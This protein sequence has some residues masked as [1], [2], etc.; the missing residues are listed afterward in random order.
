MSQ[1][2]EITRQ[3]A[4]QIIRVNRPEKKNA[5]TRAMYGAM[6]KGLEAGEADD[7]IRCHMFLGVPGA[8]SAGNDMQDFLAY[9]TSG[10]DMPEL[11]GFLETLARLR[12]A[13]RLR[14][15]RPRHRHRHD[16]PPPLRPDA[17]HAALAV[18]HAVC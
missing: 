3:G 17:R 15:R 11:I 8:F 7:A 5:F 13:G 10:G 6:W 2:I 4:V 18:P 12:K 14:R 9:A 16:H 1:H